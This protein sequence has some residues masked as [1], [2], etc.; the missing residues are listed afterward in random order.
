M[1]M[2]QVCHRFHSLVCSHLRFLDLSSSGAHHHHHH[3]DCDS[4]AQQQPSTK[5]AQLAEGLDRFLQH[6]GRNCHN[7]RGLVLPPKVTSGVHLERVAGMKG[8]TSLSLYGCSAVSD[9]DLAHLAAF[10]GLERL[11]ACGTYTTLE[12]LACL[13]SPARETAVVH[14]EHSLF[15]FPG[16]TEALSMQRKGI[17]YNPFSLF[18]TSLIPSIHK[19]VRRMHETIAWLEKRQMV[20]DR[21]IR[22]KDHYAKHYIRLNVH[23]EPAR[24]LSYY[25]KWLMSVW[26]K[27]SDLCEGQEREKAMAALRRKKMYMRQRDRIDAAGRQLA[28]SLLAFQIVHDLGLIRSRWWG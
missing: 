5:L 22:D 18:S 2:A 13:P 21:R 14:Q 3:A 6:L 19:N 15:I 10:T 12:G 9:D 27:E 7:L 1:R 20:L 28:D 25:K 4:A 23:F 16:M 8:L 26:S 24:H 11:H 17:S